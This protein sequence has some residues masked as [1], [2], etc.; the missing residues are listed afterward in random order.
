MP[1]SNDTTVKVPPSLGPIT[2]MESA[3]SSGLY[4][5]DAEFYDDF[6]VDGK[7]GGGAASSHKMSRREQNRGGLGGGSIYSSKHVRAKEAIQK[8]PKK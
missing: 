6:G 3:S 4:E 2:R 1:A 5:D 8:K 7:S